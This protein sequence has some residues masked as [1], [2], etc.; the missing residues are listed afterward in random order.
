[1]ERV[2]IRQAKARL[3]QLVV[4]ACRGKEI[5]ITR[6]SKPVVRLVAVFQTTGPRK[7]GAL[8]A[9]SSLRAMRL[10]TNGRGNGRTR[11]RVKLGAET[12]LPFAL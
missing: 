4:K 7:P 12:R 11:V 8:R 2:T 1:M 3:S 9:S 10:D 6:G 5:V